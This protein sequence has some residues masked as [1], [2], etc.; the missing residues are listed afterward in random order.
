M[1]A[2]KSS[3]AQFNEEQVAKHYAALRDSLAT[4]DSLLASGNRSSAL[5]IYQTTTPWK[6]NADWRYV[7]H[8]KCTIGPE[9]ANRATLDSLVKYGYDSTFVVSDPLLNAYLG[10]VVRSGPYPLS[11]WRSQLKL[12]V[13]SLGDLD[14]QIRHQPM[15]EAQFRE[16]GGRRDSINISLL[17]SAFRVNGGYVQSIGS[18]LILIHA[19]GFHQEHLD[20]FAQSITDGLMNQDLSNYT[21]GVIVDEFF[22]VTRDCQMFGTIGHS[23]DMPALKWCDPE[24]T[25]R[26]RKL[27][28]LPT[29]TE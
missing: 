26:L 20:Y 10:P 16:L 23:D 18:I 22:W 3:Q 27:M 17:Y 5:A 8:L 15:S 24:R 13:D 4:A 6:H 7:R 19:L 9:Q 1:I 25:M 28:G 11:R 21:Y 29:I 12:M 2:P 14:Q